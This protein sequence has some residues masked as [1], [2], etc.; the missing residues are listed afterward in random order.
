MNILGQSYSRWRVVR[1]AG[2]DR[3][4]K[5]TW[6]CQCN[7][8]T[9]RRLGEYQLTRGKT[10]SCGCYRVEVSRTKS[11]TH[12]LSHTPE[13]RIWLAIKERCYNPNSSSYARYGGIGIVVCARWRK[14]FVHFYED[15]GPRANG[16]S[17]DRKDNAKGYA[18][19]NC[20]WTT[21]EVQGNNTRRNVRYRLGALNLTLAQW[22]R[23]L[24]IG[25]STLKYR[26]SQGWSVRRMLT[27]KLR[28]RA[29]LI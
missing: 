19:G 20:R 8:G 17:I 22:T 9:I 27:T 26:K 3:H 23:W 28:R 12:G 13:H 6:I 21:R 2:L 16:L 7:C 10:H 18:P 14:S 1:Y 15:M 5:R 29:V 25:K 11:T 24:E 4:L